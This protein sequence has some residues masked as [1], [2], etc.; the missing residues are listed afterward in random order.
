MRR[1]WLHTEDCEE[2]PTGPWVKHA[3]V[4]AWLE[5]KAVE[6]E[7]I[8]KSDEAQTYRDLVADL[9]RGQHE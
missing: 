6:A 1:Y 7:R 3:D 5:A 9:A 8:C 2:T 4:Q